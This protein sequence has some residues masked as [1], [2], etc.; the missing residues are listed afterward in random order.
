MLM[1]YD[2]IHIVGLGVEIGQLIPVDVAIAAG[3]YDA[4]DAMRSGQRST[5]IAALPGPELALRAGRRALHQ[6]ADQLGTDAVLPPLHLHA[7]IHYRG[8]DFWNASCWVRHQLGIP[9]G[10]GL[11]TEINAMSNSTIGG[12]ELAASLLIGRPDLSTAL[13]T[14]GDRFG[15][16]GFPHWS[17]DVGIV[18]GDGGSALVLGRRPGIAQLVATASWCDPELEGLNRGTEPF[19]PASLAATQPIDLRRRKRAW[20]AQW[21]QSVQS[22]NTLGVSEVVTTALTEAGLD[23]GDIARVC[24]PHYGRQLTL[25]Q[26]LRPLGIPLQQ[27]T[28]DLGLQVGHLGASDQ[29]VALEHLIRTGAV[30]RGDHVVLL[31][32]G[33]GMTWTAAVVQV[34]GDRRARRPSASG[35]ARWRDRRSVRPPQPGRDEQMAP[36][37]PTG[38]ACL[39]TGQEMADRFT[40]YPGAVQ[41]ARR[42]KPD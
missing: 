26:V 39:H 4:H 23:L 2:G 7:T 1:L 27:T 11:T 41:R 21:G 13:I 38:A 34:T 8:I 40:R 24:G 22:R 37:L 33:V 16:P 35:P 10:H 20:L 17:A 28:A 5:S 3:D 31:G 30:H 32:I 25:T 9:A 6:A 12:L 14:A 36:P 15:T 42:S 29:L 19:R 18:Y